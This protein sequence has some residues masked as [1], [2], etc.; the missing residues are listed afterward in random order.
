MKG[1]FNFHFTK[2]QEENLKLFPEQRRELETI[3]RDCPVSTVPEN[4]KT[5][6]DVSIDPG[7]IYISNPEVNNSYAV[8][9]FR[10]SEFDYPVV[11]KAN[12][13]SALA[14]E[15]TLRFNKREKRVYFSFLRTV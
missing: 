10:L 6:F 13:I 15:Y 2:E 5:P 8:N 1:T 9:N 7:I 4:P 11:H 14:I 3:L 12:L